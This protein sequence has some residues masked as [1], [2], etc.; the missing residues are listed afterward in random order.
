LRL[1]PSLE[2]LCGLGLD[3][4]RAGDDAPRSHVPR[5]RAVLFCG[6]LVPPVTIGRALVF[7]GRF[8]Y[9]VVASA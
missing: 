6:D 5:S 4:D 9:S 3:D 1:V 2:F 7:R 8:A